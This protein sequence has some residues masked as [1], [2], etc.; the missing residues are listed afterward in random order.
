MAAPAESCL[1]AGVW[2]E[3]HAMWDWLKK[4][5][6]R[7]LTETE[8]RTDIHL[9]A[10]TEAALS[11]ALRKLSPGQEGWIT[12]AEAG[13]LFSAE[14]DNPLSEMDIEGQLALGRFA[15]DWRHR[16]ALRRDSDKRRI[17]FT[18]R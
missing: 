8:P 18:R 15:V 5:I 10:N 12:F 9:K 3:E 13:R 7:S 1:V 17:Y 2:P 4:L 6:G 16:S 14:D 11:R